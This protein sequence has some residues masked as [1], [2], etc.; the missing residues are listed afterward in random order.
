MFIVFAFFVICDS[1]SGW[2]SSPA[3][4]KKRGS[5]AQEGVNIFERICGHEIYIE[6]RK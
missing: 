2:N 6:I 3:Y 1:Y 5:S 4:S